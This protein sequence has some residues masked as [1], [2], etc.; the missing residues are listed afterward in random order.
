MCLYTRKCV[1]AKFHHS[2]FCLRA[3]A[4]PFR[5]MTVRCLPLSHVCVFACACVYTCAPVHTVRSRVCVRERLCECVCMCVCVFA[6]LLLAGAYARC[7]G[8]CVCPLTLTCGVTCPTRACNI[9]CIHFERHVSV[10]VRARTR[11]DIIHARVREQLV[12]GI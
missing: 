4:R 2:S 6:C 1:C 10:C 8:V 9:L 7:C 5:D 3:R 11:W 12:C